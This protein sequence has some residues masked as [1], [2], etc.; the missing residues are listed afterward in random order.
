MARARAR[1]LMGALGAVMVLA[2]WPAV[3]ATAAGD[4]TTPPSAFDI[5]PD[6]GDYQTGYSVASPYSN[7]YITWQTTTDDE[8]AVTYEVILDGTVQRIVTDGEGY[9]SVTK[10]IEVPE[11]VHEVGVVAV[12]AAGNR[13]ASTHSLDVVVDKVSPVFTSFPR[14][15]LRPG[16]VT[17]DGYPMRFTWT[18][19]DEGTGIQEVRFGPNSECCYSTSPSRTRFD[20]TIAPRSQLV[21]R[22]WLVDGVGRVAKAP[23][24]GYVAPVAWRDASLSDGWKRAPDSTAIDG[25]EWVSTKVGDRMRLTLEG[26]SVGWVTSTGPRRGRADV[27]I[28]GRVVD[29]VN[30]YSAERRSARVVWA[31]KLPIDEKATI[32]IVNRSPASR[33]LVGVDAVLLQN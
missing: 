18:G 15:L 26:R 17:P 12:D 10:R 32:T 22:I 25:S 2:A 29:T 31:S 23:R 33:P 8:S 9:T 4:D 6:L 21:W 24:D 30:L 27:L 7:I 19:T 3:P 5:L 13:R 16:P 20:F 1:W 28:D 14:L 11:G